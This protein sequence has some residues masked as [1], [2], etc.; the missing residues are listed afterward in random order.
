MTSPAHAPQPIEDEVSAAIQRAIPG[1]VVQVAGARGHFTID[2]VST[3]FE[4]KSTLA[5]HRMVLGAIA[6]LM[7]GD[8]APVHAV[9]TLTTRT[10]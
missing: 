10:P 8:G 2:V 7:A 3:A 4:G 5:K 6:S 1:C 9:D